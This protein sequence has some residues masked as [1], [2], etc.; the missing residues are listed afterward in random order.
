MGMGEGLSN[1]VGTCVKRMAIHAANSRFV[2]PFLANLTE[3]VVPIFMLHRI[4][5]EAVNGVPTAVIDDF[6]CA[7]K[8]YGYEFMSIEELISIVNRAGAPIRNKVM[9]TMDDGYIDQITK[10]L[11]VFQKHQCPISIGVITNFISGKM[12]PWDAKIRYLFHSTQRSEYTH[13][14]SCGVSIELRMDTPIVRL[15]SMRAIRESLKQESLVFLLGTITKLEVDLGVELPILPPEQYRPFSWEDI[16]RLEGDGVNFIPHTQNHYILS[17][18]S[19][20]AVYAELEGSIRDVNKHIKS[21]PAFI[22]PNG[23]LCDFNEKHIQLLRKND[24]KIAFSTHSKYL[25]LNELD[26]AVDDSYCIPRIAF[27]EN[28]NDQSSILSKLDYVASRVQ[29]RDLAAVIEVNYGI[30]RTI[31]ARVVANFTK[32][33]HLKKARNIDFKRVRR[34]VFICSGN[35]CRSPFAEI[36]A[37]TECEKLQVISMGLNAPNGDIVDSV[38][39]NVAKEFGYD[40]GALYSSKFDSGKLNSSDLLVVMEV[41]HLKELKVPMQAIGCQGT[42]LGAWDEPPMPSIYD[43]Y[44][45]NHARFRVIFSHIQSSVLGLIAKLDKISREN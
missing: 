21:V 26:R 32:R 6:L 12:W 14:T 30:K 20:E 34:V 18:L 31:A 16:K 42:L 15:H 22:Y 13:T 24:I 38:A 2:R 9:F 45:R 33:Y 39:K 4:D 1:R 43:P 36:I 40:M 28:K 7:V 17:N 5:N 41:S 8:E 23:R 44:G 29:G 37:L 35:I 25:S 19:D 27:P 10:G 11:P 3:G